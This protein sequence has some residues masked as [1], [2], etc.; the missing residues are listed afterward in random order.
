QKNRR[1]NRAYSLGI[2]GTD[3]NEIAGMI[4]SNG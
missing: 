4:D 3:A 1:S 2:Y